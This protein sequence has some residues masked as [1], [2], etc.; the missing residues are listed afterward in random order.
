MKKKKQEIRPAQVIYKMN[1]KIFDLKLAYDELISKIEKNYPSYFRIKYRSEIPSIQ[2]IQYNL[3]SP[4]QGLVEYFVG[5]SSIFIF[6][7]DKHNFQG[8]KIKKDFALE[9]M[10]YDFHQTTSIHSVMASALQDSINQRYIYLAVK[11]YEKL[12]KPIITAVPSRFTLI[13]DGIL[14]Y[15]PF[16]AL[17]VEKPTQSNDFRS[18]Q[19]L[20]RKYII[21]YNYS[22]ALLKEFL[23][24]NH[25]E[26]KKNFIGFAP[27]FKD[28]RLYSVDRLDLGP[29]KFNVPEIEMLQSMTGGDGFVNEE[30]TEENFVKHANKYKI[31]HLAT[32][33]AANDLV[34]EYSYL[35]FT[36][37]EDT[38]ENELLYAKD[39]YNLK[40]NAELVVLSACETG[41]GNMKHGEGII[42]LARGFSYS[43]ASAIV[44]SLWQINDTKVVMFMEF[45]YQNLKKGMDKDMA[46]QNAKIQY[47]N[48]NSNLVAEPFFWAPF[49]LIGNVNPIEL[50]TDFTLSFNPILIILITILL[51][52]CAIILIGK[53][54]IFRNFLSKHLKWKGLS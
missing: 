15:I 3:L 52:I 13:P 53:Q 37:K 32:H 12:F 45:F 47:I 46:L 1:S 36:E 54:K 4:G 27:Q 10:V 38:L 28:N 6:T 20:L 18:H 35:A 43:G 48:N 16:E 49:I 40:L 26:E 5:D 21:S 11:L 44:P 19:Y 25:A 29:L 31:I 50:A 7:I 33:G 51:V 14:G 17:L 24:Q 9:E 30:A 41:L 22:A 42:S 34:G 2:E 39:V 23:N 8:Y